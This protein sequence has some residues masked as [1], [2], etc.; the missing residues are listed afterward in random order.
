MNINTGE[1][2]AIPGDESFRIGS[3][4]GGGQ[5]D[6]ACEISERDKQVWGLKKSGANPVSDLSSVVNDELFRLMVETV[7]DYAIFML[8]LQGN[9]VSWN[10]GATRI[11]GYTADEVVGQ[12]IS[13]FYPPKEV[14]SGKPQYLIA[15]AVRDGRVDD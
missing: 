1:S 2:S 9:V 6:A 7:E 11:N 12:N 8:D 3:R 14:I 15:N 4:V 5:I 10:A 13:I